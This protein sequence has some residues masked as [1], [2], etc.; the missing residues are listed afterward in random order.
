M[1]FTNFNFKKQG[2][3]YLQKINPRAKKFTRDQDRYFLWIK[4]L[5]C[6]EAHSNPHS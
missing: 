5:V 3:L 1:Y 2:L 4:R 6:A